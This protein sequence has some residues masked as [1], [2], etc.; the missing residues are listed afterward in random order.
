MTT[1]PNDI[2]DELQ[3]DF[4]LARE[5][6]IEARMRQKEKDTPQNRAAVAECWARID[7]TLDLLLETRSTFLA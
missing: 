7:T 3:V 1:T 6:L 5:K 2:R 4:G